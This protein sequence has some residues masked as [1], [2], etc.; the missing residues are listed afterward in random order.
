MI[1]GA[2]RHETYPSDLSRHPNVDILWDLSLADMGPLHADLNR[3]D[4]L[5]RGEQASISLGPT[6]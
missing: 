4:G 6:G 3:A 1:S 2:Y 5:F